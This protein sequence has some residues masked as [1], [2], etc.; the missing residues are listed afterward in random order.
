M[1]YKYAVS[2]RLKNATCAGSTYGERLDSLLKQIRL[3]PPTWEE[4]TSFALINTTENIESLVDRL[5]LRSLFSAHDD[6]LIVI[7]IERGLAVT[8][9]P[10]EYPATL[11]S[12]LNGLG[13]K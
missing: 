2:Y 13:Q 10:I 5:Y 8:K 7:D 1:A 11:G 6:L 3:T 9:G 12:L 4:T